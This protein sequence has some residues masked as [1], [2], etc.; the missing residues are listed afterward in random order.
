MKW[1]RNG[2]LCLGCNGVHVIWW[3]GLIFRLLLQTHPPAGHPQLQAL[4]PG[5]DPVG[6]TP[7]MARW[8]P[9]NLVQKRRYQLK[10]RAPSLDDTPGNTMHLQLQAQ[11]RSPLFGRQDV[12][13]TYHDSSIGP[14]VHH[15]ARTM[16]MSMMHCAVRWSVIMRCVGSAC[17]CTYPTDA[18]AGACAL[19]SAPPSGSLRRVIVDGE[20]SGSWGGMLTSA[21]VAVLCF[22][23][24]SLRETPLHLAFASAD[25]PQT[26]RWGYAL[27]HPLVERV[28]HPHLR[29]CACSISRA[30]EVP[31]LLF[32]MPSA[33]SC[34]IH[35]HAPLH[36]RSRSSTPCLRTRSLARLASDGACSCV[37]LRCVA[38]VD[39]SLPS[40]L[41]MALLLLCAVH[42]KPVGV[43]VFGF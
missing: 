40:W 4:A 38:L 17:L 34:W 43:G 2:R 36:L 24:R 37:F 25:P 11:L 31:R 9:V 41:P 14:S 1:G 10:S 27:Q 33:W 13:P 29:R 15:A 42:G 8:V 16:S 23:K 26:T 20:R 18:C 39:R 12:N 19:A 32:L 3:I 5:K 28:V 22:V 35:A 6:R 30:W 21:P 7:M